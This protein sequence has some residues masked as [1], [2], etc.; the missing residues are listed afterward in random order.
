MLIQGPLA[1]NARAGTYP[2]VENANITTEN[3]GSP[4]RIRRWIDC[5]VH[6]QG[7]PEW[8]FLKLH[9]HGAIERDF[10]AL[11]GGR[12]RKMHTSLAEQYNDGRHFRLH[13]I[14]ARHAFNLARAAE[15]GASGDPSQF[16]DWE[17]PAQ[18]TSRYWSS[19]P[20]DLSC[21]TAERLTA[22]GFDCSKGATVD[23][24][25]PGFA[26]ISGP[27]SQLDVSAG[28]VALGLPAQAAASFSVRLAT[29]FEVKNLSGARIVSMDAQSGFIMEGAGEVQLELGESQAAGI[30]GAMA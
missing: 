26:Q 15:A 18:T 9:T 30:R 24:R 28:H 3:W 13:Y 21:C 23:L 1:I 4:D 20:H 11:F 6:V 16:L 12:A 19:A 7:R 25:Y 17:V 29:G 10:D 5:H 8:V 2:R 14:T 22:T 27:F